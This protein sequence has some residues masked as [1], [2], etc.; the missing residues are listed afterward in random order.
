MVEGA[1]GLGAVLL[2]AC[3]VLGF[4]LEAGFFDFL[5]VGIVGVDYV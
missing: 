2:F 4:A 1:L 3:D 5:V